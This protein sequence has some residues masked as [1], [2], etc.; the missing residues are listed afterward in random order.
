MFSIQWIMQKE[1]TQLVFTSR[2]VYRR[3]AWRMAGSSE[4]CEHLCLN[5]CPWPGRSRS[6][7]KSVLHAE[8]THIWDTKKGKENGHKHTQYSN[9]WNLHWAVHMPL[10]PPAHPHPTMLKLC[11]VKW[12]WWQ[13]HHQDTVS[14][15]S[16][17]HLH[18]SG[19]ND[20]CQTRDGSTSISESSSKR[21]LV[22]NN[23]HKTSQKK[24]PGNASA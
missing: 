23:H 3:N 22:T 21:R 1:S 14:Q 24:T 7:K 13:D 9:H 16:L 6:R 19:N 2:I 5:I 18:A 15:R 10:P 12:Y 11:K 20:D 17:E 8:S 4:R